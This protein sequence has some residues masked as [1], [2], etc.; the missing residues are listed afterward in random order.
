MVYCVTSSWELLLY[1]WR[2]W[3]LLEAYDLYSTSVFIHLHV[4]YS[5]FM[6]P[7]MKISLLFF[8]EVCNTQLLAVILQPIYSAFHKKAARWAKSLLSFPV[9]K[10]SCSPSLISEAKFDLQEPHKCWPYLMKL[11]ASLC[12]LCLYG[13][14]WCRFSMIQQCLCISARSTWGRAVSCS[15][16][17]L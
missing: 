5:H 16:Q 9:S 15:E 8:S 7:L 10:E 4:G 3:K 13:L 11:E 12:W 1:F 6:K 2:C 17:R 14:L